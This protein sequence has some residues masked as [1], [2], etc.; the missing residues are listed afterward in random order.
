MDA[1]SDGDPKLDDVLLF[2]DYLLK[3]ALAG[4]PI[5][6][7]GTGAPNDLLEKLTKINSRFAMGIARG[8]SVREILESNEDWPS[9]YRSALST[10]L[11]CDRSPKALTALSE[12]ADG[13]NDMEKLVS[14]SL[15]QP[16]MLFVLVYLGLLS[17]LFF[18]A[19]KMVAL[20]N[21]IHAAPG[22]GLRFLTIAM[23][24]MWN[25]GIAV[26]LLVLI[27]MMVWRYTRLRWTYLWFP[28]RRRIADAIQK[29]NYAESMANLIEHDHSESQAR[30][31]VAPLP[32]NFANTTPILNW[33]LGSDVSEGERASALHA[34]AQAYRN[35]A[36]SRTNRLFAWFP[37]FF[38]A[39]FGGA[40][41]L[42][43]GLSLFA[44]MIELLLSLSR[45]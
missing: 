40:L 36:Q 41:V 37:V 25:W 5:G 22:L 16:L 34:T 7:D 2:N 44:P 9:Q 35:L 4:V 32:S 43:Y 45:P 27:G 17:M 1:T 24:T 31:L 30:N 8:G 6:L 38:S 28:G 20:S 29:A 21:Q 33:A 10:W 26:P 23:Q 11:F 42:L 3:L 19:P 15:L 14:F 12:C 39:I 13:R 18:L